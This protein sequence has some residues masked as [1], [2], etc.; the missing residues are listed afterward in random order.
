MTWL[1]LTD[2]KANRCA[3]GFSDSELKRLLQMPGKKFH[4]IVRHCQLTH[5][6]IRPFL[7]RELYAPHF[8]NLEQIRTNFPMLTADNFISYTT[9]ASVSQMGF[10]HSFFVDYL[11]NQKDIKDAIILGSF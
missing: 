5:Q 6:K 7:L 11:R 10:P 9:F 3:H 2:L 8:H 1:T 4:D